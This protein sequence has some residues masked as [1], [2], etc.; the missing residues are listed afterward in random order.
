[1]SPIQTTRKSER[2]AIRLDP[3][4]QTMLNDLADLT[5]LSAADVV[6]QLIRK[7][8]KKQCPQK[9]EPMVPAKRGRK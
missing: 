8:H 4:E 5:G 2:F 3:I 6:R 9:P 1:M 7:E